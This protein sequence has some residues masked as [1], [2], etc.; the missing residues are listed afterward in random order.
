MRRVPTGIGAWLVLVAGCVGPTDDPSDVHDLRVLGVD[1]E[2]PEIMAPTCSTSDP[3]VLLGAASAP[4]TYNALIADPDGGGRTID[5]EL[6]AC[7][8]PADLTCSNA[9]ETIRLEVGTT[10]AANGVET[11]LTLGLSPGP[12]SLFLPSTDGGNPTPLLAQVIADDPYH[13]LGGVNLPLVLHLRAG[14]EEIWAQKLMVY[15][16]PY[17]PDMKP[18]TTPQIPG[19]QANGVEWP[20]GVTG[21]TDAGL[22]ITIDDVSKLE[23]TY[24]VPSFNLQE[25]Y[26]TESWVID[27]YTTL[28][29]FSPTETG[30]TDLGGQ[31]S[32]HVSDWKLPSQASERDVTFWFV[33][34]NGRGGESWTQRDLH[35]SP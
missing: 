2:P 13:G 14:T 4:I 9:W 10:A 30:G 31:T 6:Y 23:A 16:C 22:Q 20:D 15:S 29:T 32:S 34:R 7:A 8:D 11:V 3:T 18:Q 27:Y 26:L 35:Y 25:V 12:G 28:G 1:L 21:V 19:L 5:Y 17:F 24:G 33:V